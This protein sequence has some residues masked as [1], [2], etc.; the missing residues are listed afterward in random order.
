MSGDSLRHTALMRSSAKSRRRRRTRETSEGERWGDRE[1]EG[2]D[3]V[4]PAMMASG[5]RR[6]R[7]SGRE[8]MTC[9]V[10]GEGGFL[11]WSAWQRD[12]NRVDDGQNYR[13]LLIPV[14]VSFTPGWFPNMPPGRAIK[15]TTLAPLSRLL[16]PSASAVVLLLYAHVMPLL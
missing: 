15:H 14:P 3:T 10:P 7:R 11:Q 2:A 8:E 12:G 5:G 4:T 9:T 6:R 1:T 16:H 13:G